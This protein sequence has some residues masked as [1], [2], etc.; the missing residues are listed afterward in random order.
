MILEQNILLVVVKWK[1]II[2]GCFL[3]SFS[4]FDR[5][6]PEEIYSIFKTVNKKSGS[7]TYLALFS[8]T[9]VLPI[10]MCTRA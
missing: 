10:L 4:S 5:V 8:A 1:T 7:I 9:G 6:V 2:L 3:P